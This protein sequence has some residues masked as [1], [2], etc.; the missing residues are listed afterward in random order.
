M[1]GQRGPRH[2]ADQ[3]AGP[4]LAGSVLLVVAGG[5]FISKAGE[6]DIDNFPDGVWWSLSTATGYGDFFPH[7]A[8]GRIVGPCSSCSSES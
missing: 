7:T 3:L 1:A 5:L 2:P 8:E 4:V 6:P